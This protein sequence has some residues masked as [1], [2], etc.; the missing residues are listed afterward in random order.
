[1]IF[2]LLFIFFQLQLAS[3]DKDWDRKIVICDTSLTLRHLAH[4]TEYTGPLTQIC[5]YTMEG[6]TNDTMYDIKLIAVNSYGES[7]ASKV[8]SFYVTGTPGRR[9]KVGKTDKTLKTDG[10]QGIQID[11][12]NAVPQKFELKKTV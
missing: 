9:K 7:K 1:M 3:P 2:L 8:F 4:V 6:L 5:W 10:S 11:I 12:E